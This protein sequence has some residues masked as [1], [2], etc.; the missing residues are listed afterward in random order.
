[1]LLPPAAP[2]DEPPLPAPAAVPPLFVPAPLVPF[3]PPRAL[4]PPLVSPD[5]GGSDEQ[6][7]AANARRASAACRRN[8]FQ[9]QTGPSRFSAMTQCKSPGRE[10]TAQAQAPPV[11]TGALSRVHERVNVGGHEV[12]ERGGGRRGRAV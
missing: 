10:K 11:A 7:L 6:P 12:D 1:M 5:P 8:W 2:P 9:A 4:L 3:A